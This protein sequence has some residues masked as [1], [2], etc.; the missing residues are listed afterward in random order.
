MQSTSSVESTRSPVPRDPPH[1]VLGRLLS[2]LRGDKY[3]ADAYP[4]RWPAAIPTSADGVVPAG[5]QPEAAVPARAPA[6]KEP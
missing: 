6:I 1:T 2:M 5:Q 3:M 4:P